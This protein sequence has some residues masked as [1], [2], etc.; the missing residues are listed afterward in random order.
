M[1]V[2]REGRNMKGGEKTFCKITNDDIYREQISQ[3]KLLEEMTTT[4]KVHDEQ[5]SNLKKVVYATAGSLVTFAVSVVVF[6]IT[7]G[8]SP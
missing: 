7:R 8:A 5:I 3:R 4:I 1:A 2:K 6:F